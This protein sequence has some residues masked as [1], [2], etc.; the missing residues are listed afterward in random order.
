[1]DGREFSRLRTRGGESILSSRLIDR[2]GKLSGLRGFQILQ[3]DLDQFEILLVTDDA[4]FPALSNQV[5][6][7]LREFLAAEGEIEVVC[8]RVEELPL[9]PSGKFE[10]VRWIGPSEPK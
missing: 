5:E 2:F 10:K 9:S 7:L 6:T 8:R 3:R 4:S 1:M